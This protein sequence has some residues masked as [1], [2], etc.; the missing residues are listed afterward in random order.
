MCFFCYTKFIPGLESAPHNL[1]CSLKL[2]LWQFQQSKSMKERMKICK[3]K[4]KQ[5]SDGCN[6]TTIIERF[7]QKYTQIMKRSLFYYFKTDWQHAHNFMDNSH[8][9]FHKTHT[10][11]QTRKVKV[12]WNN[13]WIKSH[14]VLLNLWTRQMWRSDGYL[15]NVSLSMK[16]YGYRL[17]RQLTSTPMSED[18]LIGTWTH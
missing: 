11:V 16:G 8:R 2:H 10:S 1:T 18:W 14:R 12:L 9:I 13:W 5:Q 15:W 7:W 6:I 4:H 17:F 3:S